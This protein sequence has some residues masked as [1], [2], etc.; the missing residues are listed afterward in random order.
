VQWRS[1]RPG[2]RAVVAAL[3]S[4]SAA[5]QFEQEA[6]GMTEFAVD[7]VEV[8]MIGSLEGARL[9]AKEALYRAHALGT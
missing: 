7:N 5:A 3:A 2:A 4:S 9:E 6:E 1:V 8:E